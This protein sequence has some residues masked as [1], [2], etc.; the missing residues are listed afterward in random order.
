L[1]SVQQFKRANWMELPFYRRIYLIF[2]I[3][4]SLMEHGIAAKRLIT[5]IGLPEKRMFPSPPLVCYPVGIESL[6]WGL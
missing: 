5:S 1:K 2:A 6:C 4:L 3:A